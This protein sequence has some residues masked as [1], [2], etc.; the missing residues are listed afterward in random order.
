[1]IKYDKPYL[2]IGELISGKDYDYV[3]Y[4]VV[5]DSPYCDKENGE[6]TGCFAVN[7][8]KIVPLDGDCYDYYEEVIASEEWSQPEDG[9]IK[10][11]TIIVECEVIRG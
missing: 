1:M 10:G 4:R 11:L 7:D 8:G 5:Y 9:V 3:S 6:F 2:T